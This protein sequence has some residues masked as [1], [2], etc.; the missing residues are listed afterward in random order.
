MGLILVFRGLGMGRCCG[1]R[2]RNFQ[3]VGRALGFEGENLEEWFGM[4]SNECGLDWKSYND[5]NTE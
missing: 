1:I 2:I 5:D 3:P 4:G